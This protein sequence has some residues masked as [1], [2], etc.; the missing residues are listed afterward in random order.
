MV[1]TIIN[2]S[3]CARL[4]SLLHYHVDFTALS[5]QVVPEDCMDMDEVLEDDLQ[6]A[7]RY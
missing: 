1:G 2:K 6:T 5:G 3:G 4:F 7:S